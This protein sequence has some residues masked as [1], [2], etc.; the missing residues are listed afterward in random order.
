MAIVI[1]NCQREY[2]IAIHADQVC[3]FMKSSSS[4]HCSLNS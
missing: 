4:E 2:H 1:V 3:I